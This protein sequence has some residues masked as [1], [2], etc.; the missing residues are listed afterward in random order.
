MIDIFN[1]FYK[2]K[3][4]LVTGHTG[5]KGSWLSIWL[6][7]LGAEVIGIAKEPFSERDNYVL[8]GI[9]KKINADNWRAE[10][11]PGDLIFIGTKSGR[12]T[13][14]GIY[15]DDGK[16]IHSSGRVKINSMDPEASD[17]LDYNYLSMSR[18]KGEVG[19]KGIVAVRNHEW[20][21]NK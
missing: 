18:I 15:L 12:V 3:R 20:Y 6:H 1:G 5:F 11:E 4:V 7:K 8:S 21:F 17:F 9:G 19:T 10:A 2:G 16:Y 14:V 13:H